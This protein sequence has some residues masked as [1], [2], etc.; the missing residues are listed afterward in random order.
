MRAFAS[1]MI[2]IP[3]IWYVRPIASITC[4]GVVAGNTPVTFPAAVPLVA[5]REAAMPT[6]WYPCSSLPIREIKSLAL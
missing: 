4:S 5:K 2:R 6:T 3:V 1:W